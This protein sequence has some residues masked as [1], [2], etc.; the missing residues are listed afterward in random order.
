MEVDGAMR[1]QQEHVEM[2]LVAI[3][4]STIHPPAEA[5]QDLHV[6]E[7]RKLVTIEASLQQHNVAL[8]QP[9]L[10]A[11]LRSTDAEVRWL[12]AQKL[13]NDAARDAIPAII[14]ALDAEKVPRTKVNIASA[15]AQLGDN[16]GTVALRDV[17]DDV[18]TRS[19]I[20][21][22]AA[23]YLL[24][25]GDEHCLG[26]VVQILSSKPDADSQVQALSLLPRFRRP[27]AGLATMVLNLV[28]ASL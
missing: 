13:A 21:M 9:A 5:A 6:N 2:I 24:N 16:R 27:P 28:M 11:A 19:S 1:V 25:V 8:T 7:K 12:A 14:E 22:L 20:R 4:F 18:R 17:C 15:L 10:L 3:L 26:S 23:Q